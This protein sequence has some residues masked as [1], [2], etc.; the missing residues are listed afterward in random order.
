[1]SKQ[2]EVPTQL[3]EVIA[4]LLK[5][6]EPIT[7]V[8]ITPL[9]EEL[10]Y[11]DTWYLRVTVRDF[12]FRFPWREEITLKVVSEY[13]G[14]IFRTACYAVDSAILHGV[15]IGSEIYKQSFMQSMASLVDMSAKK[16]INDFRNRN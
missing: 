11:W 12:S 6:W 3:Q 5:N 9:Y 7:K 2:P 16:S 8:E 1:M 13:Y 10:E 15:T 4:E 14:H